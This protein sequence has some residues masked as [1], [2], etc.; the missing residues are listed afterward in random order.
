MKKLA[1]L[2]F[3]LI[4]LFSP[5]TIAEETA[6]EP[7]SGGG[8]GSSSSDSSS[9]SPAP[10]DSGS[11]SDSGSTSS[12]SGSSSEPT[13]PTPT[14]DSGTTDTVTPPSS[15]GGGEGGGIIEQP[16]QEPIK[17]P[18]QQPQNTCPPDKSCRSGEECV[19]CPDQQQKQQPY[20]QQPGQPPQPPQNRCPSDRACMKG[21]E[22]VPCPGQGQQF[23][24]IPPGCH[25]EQGEFGQFIKCEQDKRYEEEKRKGEEDC[26]VHNGKFIIRPGTTAWE[27]IPQSQGGFFNQGQCP[28]P[29][30][31]KQIETQ[32]TSSQGRVEHF[33]DRNGCE[34]SSCMQEFS[35]GQGS[36]EEKIKFMALSCEGQGG[37]FTFNEQGPNCVGGQQQIRINQD[38]KPLNG[39]EL[40]KIALEMEN[41][42]QTFNNIHDKL[43]SLQS[44]YQEK[45]DEEKAASF[46]AAAS[47]LEGAMNR[48]DEIRAGLAENADSFEEQ[49]RISVLEDIQKINSIIKD[50]AVI[51]LTGGKS[52]RAATERF[53]QR[54]G[55]QEFENEFPEE[56]EDVFQAFQNCQDFSKDAPFKFSPEKGVN[57]R[58]EGLDDGKC[59]MIV[60]PPGFEGE[61][62][63]KIPSGVYQFFDGPQSLLREDVECSP[64]AACEMMKQFIQSEDQ[65]KGN[66]QQNQQRFGEEEKQREFKEG[67]FQDFQSP[68]FPQPRGRFEQNSG[69]LRPSQCEGAELSNEECAKWT[70]ETNSL[71]KIPQCKGL[72]E[73]QCIKLL[74]NSWDRAFESK[75]FNPAQREFPQ[76]YSQY[77]PSSGGGMGQGGGYNQYSQNTG[78]NN[79][80]NQQGYQDNYQTARPAVSAK[81]GFCGDGTIAPSLGEECDDRNNRDGDG[82]STSCKVE[83]QPVAIANVIKEF[84]NF[85]RGE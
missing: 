45:G 36:E 72:T 48:L 14:S 1:A 7:A 17:E 13:S 80:N 34:I 18:Y 39:I 21:E 58:L 68:E 79:F 15:G 81:A 19:P 30:Q 33:R 75:G 44:Y 23:Q 12:D 57:V 51:L 42:I 61:V 49:E 43:T 66:A 76:Q 22:C 74:K 83:Q 73:E 35:Q 10:S 4:L 24:N 25:V 82:C 59:V 65:N 52:K 63:F 29:E 26:R 31:L 60:N 37:Q 47:Q 40:L 3:I 77:Q 11:S 78:P 41:L 27:C 20:Q 67:E 69:E 16:Y 54:S 71:E 28:G 85:M 8:G 84:G 50:V 32:C 2:L 53:E 6:T 9:E 38:L 62:T 70:I 56:G 5:I 64:S 46:A 55:K